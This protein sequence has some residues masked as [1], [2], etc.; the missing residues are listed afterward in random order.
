MLKLR[1]FFPLTHDM[2]PPAFGYVASSHVEYLNDMG[3]VPLPRGLS[4]QPNLGGEE[5]VLR[6]SPTPVA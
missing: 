1:E 2:P 3:K 4:L 6:N 5:D